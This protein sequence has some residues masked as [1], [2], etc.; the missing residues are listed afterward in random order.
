MVYCGLLS[1]IVVY[2]CLLRSL[3]FIMVYCVSF[4]VFGYQDMPWVIILRCIR[5]PRWIS[6]GQHLCGLWG[7]GLLGTPSGVGGSVAELMCGHGQVGSIADGTIHRD[8]YLIFMWDLQ[9]D[10]SH[11]K[12][13]PWWNLFHSYW[14][15]PSRKF[16]SFPIHS[17]VIFHSF[18]LYTTREYII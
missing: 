17:M 11:S 4:I 15:W 7:Y 12:S 9:D 16:V 6:R 18:L 10:H 3:S 13:T 1:F 5:I 14:T 8:T 2:W